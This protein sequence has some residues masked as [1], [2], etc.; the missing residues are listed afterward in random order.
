MPLDIAILRFFNITIANPVLDLIFGAFNGFR[1]WAV[2]FG[3]IILL[4]LWKG[5][6]RGRWLVVISLLT[7]AI[8]DPSVHYILKPLFHRF[9][10]CQPEEGLTWLR[11]IEGCG[12]RYGFPSSHAANSFSQTVV[13]GSFYRG[14]RKFLYPLAIL[15]SLSRIYLGVHYPSDVLGGAIYGAAIGLIVLYLVNFFAP[16]AIGRYLRHRR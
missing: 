6:A 1:L 7:V 11:L 10:P 2:P 12:G 14:S 5:G 16:G 13:I 3:I 9:R 4:L 8:I 15:I